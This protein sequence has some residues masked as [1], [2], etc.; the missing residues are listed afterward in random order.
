MRIAD[1]SRPVRSRASLDG[2]WAFWPDVAGALPSGPGAPFVSASDRERALGA[3][4]TARVPAPWQAQF[5]ELRGWAG[6]AWYERRFAVPDVPPGGGVHLGFGAVDYFATV[7]VNGRLAGEHEG[8]YLPFWLDASELVR[9]GRPNT[10]TVRAIDVGADQED[11]PFPFSEIPHGK[12]SWYG[13]IGGIWQSVCVEGRGPAFVQSVR[14][15]ADPASGDVSTTLAVGGSSTGRAIAWRILDRDAAA[16]AAGILQPGVRSFRTRVATANSWSPDSPYLYRLELEM[17]DGRVLVDRFTERFG[18]RS[19][20]V[21]DGR[22]VLNDEPVYLLGALDQDY[23]MP[24]IST[25]G[26]DAA[27]EEQM[28]RAKEL[29]LNL[30]RCHIKIPEPRYLAAADRAGIL[31]WCEV[32]SWRRLTADAERRVRDTFEGMVRRD[33]NHPSLIIRSVVNEDWGTDLAAEATDRAWLGDTF[34]WA[35]ALDPTR[36]VVDNSACPPNFHVE[37]DLNDYHVYRAVPEQTDSWRRWT[38]RFVSHP[39]ATYSPHGDAIVH[40]SEPLVL[41]EFG[42]WGLPDVDGLLDETG[43]EPWW[44]G[45]GGD[46]GDSIVR[47]AGV[48]ERFEAWGLGRVFGS[49]AAFARS[50]QEHAFEGLKLQIE[51]LRSHAEIA[52]Y[53]VT[54]F[55]DVHWEANGLLDMRRGVKAFHDRFGSINAPD[56]VLIRPDR[57]RYRSRETVVADVH[58]VTRA[59]LADVEIGWGVDG[60]DL[61]GTVTSGGHITFT[62]PDVTRPTRTAVRAAPARGGSDGRA[63]EAPIWLFPAEA[64]ARGSEVVVTDRWKEAGR[65]LEA[66]RRVLIVGATTDA[67]PTGSTIVLEPLEADEDEGVQ[68]VYRDGW[69]L[70][71]GMGWLSPVLGDGLAVGPAL[72][73]AFEGLAPRFL[74]AGYTSAEHLDV[75]AGHHLGWLHRVRASVAAFAHGGGAGIICTLPLLDVDGTDP[76][77]TALLDRMVEIASAPGFAPRRR[78]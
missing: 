29:G 69:M 42:L 24:D 1:R 76:L 45:T 47:P 20:G 46:D 5:E 3:A 68:A 75:L 40:G 30:L 19:V 57:R 59:G 70:S 21:A 6:T 52:G 34:R 53:V 32:P 7:W 38:T 44:F 27:I 11:P 4:R 22:V 78:L 54:E 26:S 48:R 31:T 49:F 73:L 56:V 16:V 25:A 41:S 12:Q 33:F 61:S 66:G 36:L 17:R 77:A 51:D 62:A 71:T 50:S 14:I 8:G 28:R 58:A 23:W 65:V 63:N 9:P 10:V 35:K 18:F 72:G 39:D 37:S 67:L 13:P 15:V 64:T 55:T 2:T 60:F 74:L 43:R